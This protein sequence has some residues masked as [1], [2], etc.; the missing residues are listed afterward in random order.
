MPKLQLFAPCERVIIEEGAN[1]VSLIALVQDIN[2]HHD[3]SKI[4][5]DALGP[6]RWYVL[7]VW[8]SQP[9][10]SGHTFEQRIALTDPAG[11]T[12]IET[13]TKM[14][15]SK[16]TLRTVGAFDNFPIGQEGVCTLDLSLKRDAEDFIHVADYPLKVVYH[17]P[18]K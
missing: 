4:P 9:E 6:L 1:T 11:K 8:A 5:A 16:D 2:V 14:D 17:A 18:R 15:L 3:P 7:T 13:V 10:D 12:R